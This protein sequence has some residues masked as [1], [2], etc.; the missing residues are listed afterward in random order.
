MKGP[1]LA[2]EALV[3]QPSLRVVFM[4]GYNEESILG[5]RLG[6]EGTLLIQKPF[7][8]DGLARQIRHVLDLPRES[9]VF[10]GLGASS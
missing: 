4:S 8:P 10:S 6:E 3:L 9:S 5:K 2:R 1:E 7:T